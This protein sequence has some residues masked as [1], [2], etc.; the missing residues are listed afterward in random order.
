ML[1]RL[2]VIGSDEA[3]RTRLAEL[4]DDPALQVLP[5]EKEAPLPPGT[6]AAV[7]APDAPEWSLRAVL[8]LGE[9]R[10]RTLDLLAEAIDCREELQQGSSVRVLDHASR[11]AQA[12]DFAPDAR[13]ALERAAL[14]RGVGK[15]RISNDIL[16]KK[17]LL[18]YDEWTTLKGH[19][20]I[21]AQMLQEAGIFL[22]AVAIIRYHHECWDGTG[23]PHGL[24][25]EAIPYGA[26]VL[27]LLDVFCAM[28][29]P[30]AYRSGQATR[31]EALAHLQEERGK[32]FDPAVV[33]AF[34]E[35]DIGRVPGA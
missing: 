13:I 15:L 5:M 9:R 6:I 20:E 4:A 1:K 22:D 33:D 30:R 31:D 10:A 29:S 32:H 28:T 34:I 11:F 23:Y 8:Q 14:L 7:L 3:L 12:L 27:R 2:V 17:S 18:D 16:L 35:H 21:G 25:G 19:P 24:E 26:R